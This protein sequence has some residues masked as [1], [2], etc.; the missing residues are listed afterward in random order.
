VLPSRKHAT[1]AREQIDLAIAGCG[2]SGAA[3]ALAAAQKGIS[4]SIFEEHSRVGEPSHCSGHVGI[5]AFEQFAPKIPRRIVENEIRG[6][7]LYP[8]SERPLTLKRTTPVTWVLN[9]AE[10]DRHLASVATA[11]GAR[12]RLNSRIEGFRQLGQG[13]QIKIAGAKSAE[14]SCKML[15]DA[16]GFGGSVSKFAGLSQASPRMLVNSAQFSVDNVSD[17]DKDFVELYFGQQYAPGFFGWIIPRRD[18]SAKVGIAAGA[19]ANVRRCFE[20][21]VSKHP[22][23]SKKLKH[24]RPMTQTMFH[25]IPVDG[26]TRRTYAEG[27]LS[28]GD[29]ASQVKPTTGGGIVFGLACG[30][31]AGTTAANAVTTGDTSARFLSA[32][33]KSW[34]QLIGFDLK[35]MSWLRRL[36]YRLPDQYLDRIFKVSNELR[37]DDILNRSSDIDFQG[38]TLVS[39]ARDPRLFLTLLSASV[40]SAPSLLSSDAPIPR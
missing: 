11:A 17:V 20:R 10:F 22:V 29:A 39:L 3:A 37:A 14:V 28:V 12:L 23:V 38:K 35:A 33:E 4:V 6:A 26:A 40:L 5:R 1:L 25:P 30:R 18:G 34:R 8:P 21:F 13:F 15:I 16:S 7:M 24:A 2:V 27:I 32:Y 19:R 31:I 9:R 36:L